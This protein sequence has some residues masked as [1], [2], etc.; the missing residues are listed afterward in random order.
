MCCWLSVCCCSQADIAAAKPAGAA[1]GEG[2]KLNWDAPKVDE[3]I[4]KLPQHAKVGGDRVGDV[5]VLII[6]HCKGRGDARICV[7]S[8]CTMFSHWQ[9]VRSVGVQPL[10]WCGGHNTTCSHCII[11]SSYR[12]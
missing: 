7:T 2:S 9:G 8:F 3:D 10:V 12:P 11:V 5:G 6:K 4:T 1:G